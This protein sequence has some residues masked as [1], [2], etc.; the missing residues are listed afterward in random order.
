VLNYPSDQRTVSRLVGTL[1]E[2]PAERIVVGNGASELIKIIAGHLPGRI[3]C[4]VPSFN[5]YENAAQDG[6]FDPFPLPAPSFELDVDAFAK[7]AL[8]G[9]AR[10]AVV[11][12]PNNPTGLTVPRADLLRLAASLQAG[13]CRLIVD[14]S[15]IDFSPQKDTLTVE[16]ALD[17]APNI[18]VLK[19]LS[20]SF[21]IGGIR[22][23]YLVTADE[24]LLELIRS[25]L[26]IW[27]INGFAES[28]L[29]L[30][31]RY[32]REFTQ[33]CVRVT[34]DCAGLHDGLRQISGMT[35][36][37]SEANFVMCRLPSTAP[38][39][40]EIAKEMFIK[41]NIFLKHCAGKPM[42]EADRFLR[43]ASRTAADNDTLVAGLARLLE[44]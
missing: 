1:I 42:P 44:M 11:V 19:S 8:D 40:P 35:V 27:N 37:K 36:Y 43:I 28:F 3:V 2:Q 13:D 31:P 5:E 32:R 21:G 38:S 18:S 4:P 22:L 16:G 41:H 25:E 33:S 34:S 39:G 15:F 24:D 7:A 9:D 20:K 30:A 23:G 17:K 14:E 12:S 29:R 6:Q 26:H 10:F